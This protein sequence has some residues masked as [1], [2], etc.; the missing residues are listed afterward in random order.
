MTT[1]AADVL[2]VLS[3]HIGAANGITAADL[4]ASL[5]CLPRTVR[6]HVSELRLSG[7]AVCGTPKTGYYIAE[8]GAELE[9]TCQF[10]RARALHSLA[11]E[12]SLRKT[13]LP[14]LIGQLH[15]PT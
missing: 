15:L 13:P 2:A 10:L 7:H 12:A 14:D 5:D 6:Q 1:T 9:A 3:A 8:T 11:L 4:A